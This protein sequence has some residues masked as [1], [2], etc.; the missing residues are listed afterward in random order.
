MAEIEIDITELQENHMVEYM[1]DILE[2]RAIPDLRDGLKPVQRYCVWVSYDNGYLPSKPYVKNA[3]IVGKIIGEYNPHGDASAYQALTRLA[4]PF[5]NNLTLMDGHG[6]MGTI[7]GDSPAAYRYTEGRLSKFGLELC[8]NIDKNAVDF[9]DNYTVTIKEPTILPAKVCNLL[10]NGAVGI[11]SGFTSSIPP[12]NINDVCDAT[13]KLIKEPDT[14]LS[15]FAKNLRPDFPTGGII[16]NSSEITE[17]YKTGKGVIKV[18]GKAEIITKKNGTSVIHI[19]E[20]PYLVTIGPR[21]VPGNSAPESGL[22]NSIVDKIKSEVIEG[23]SDIQDHSKKNIDIDIFVKKDYDPNVILQQLYKYTKLENTFKIQLVCLE[24]K[25]YQYY[26]VKTILEKF[27]AFRRTTIKRIIVF[28]INKIKRR[29]HIIDGLIIALNDIDEVIKIIKS[30]NDDKIAATKLKKKLPNLTLV[31]IAA[32][33]EMKLSTLTGLQIE[34]LKKEKSDKENK[35]KE[36]MDDLQPENIDKKIIEE[37]NEIKKKYGYPRKTE[38]CDIDTNITEE[39]IIP[40][41]E[42]A[43]I[44][45]KNDYVKRISVSSFKTQKRNTQGNNIADDT[46]DIF[47]ANTKDHLLCF[48]NTGRVFDLKVYKI[49]ECSVK[50]K[51]IKLPIKL[52]ENEK[53]VKTL[54]LTDT[55]IANEEETSYLMFVTKNGMGKK[56]SLSEYKNIQSS[57]IIATGLNNNDKIVFVGYIDDSLKM[58]DII[59][60]STSGNVARYNHEEFKPLGR[61]ASGVTVMSLTDKEAI[62]NACIIDNHDD[63]LFFVTKNGFGKVSKITDMEDGINTGFPRLKRS[64]N[65]KGRIGIKLKAGDKLRDVITMPAHETFKDLII[66]TNSKILTITTEDILKPLKRPTYGKRLIN[67]KTEDDYIISVAFK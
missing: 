48:T 55:Q 38:L 26:D 30:S 67:M 45:T 59:V 11:A 22:I 14:P 31:Q 29:I 44:L 25:R 16:C 28:D 9:T 35:V 40:D 15:Y 63:N 20:I 61:T 52:K 10:V 53:I 32:I 17:S 42:C 5:S 8:E 65:I 2:D 49:P 34:N 58:Q 51:G 50:N 4:Q 7:N 37:Q 56:T 64:S 12:H 57:G 62:A 54:C 39:D 66:T 27:L 24:N 47:M 36:L 46:R 3:Q 21:I 13:I 1:R 23:V 43:V 6:N 19:S 33:L 18:R 60:A 41:E